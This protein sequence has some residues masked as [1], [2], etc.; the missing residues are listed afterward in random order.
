ME[1]SIKTIG[2]RK[3]S[4]A[5]VLV[6]KGSGKITV[7][8]K[9]PST[10]FPSQ[11]IINDMLSPLTLTK[12]SDSLDVK[13]KVVGGGY[14]GQAGA[15]RLGIARAVKLLGQE[16]ANSQ[17]VQANPYHHTL[18]SKKLLTRDPRSKE[19]KKFGKYGAR[20]SPQFVKR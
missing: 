1:N 20:R 10:Y 2:R 18:K 14:S 15:I 7:N 12:L 6:T 13:A 17:E 4:V 8:G 3:S 5:N 19:R 16:S 11:I 9:D